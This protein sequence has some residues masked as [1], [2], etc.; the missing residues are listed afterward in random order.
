MGVTVLEGFIIQQKKVLVT[1]GIKLYLIKSGV[2][3]L[4]T[5]TLA[6]CLDSLP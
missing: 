3:F 1:L 5:T 6:Q 4:D 2:F